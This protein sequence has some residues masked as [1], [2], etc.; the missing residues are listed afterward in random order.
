MSSLRPSSASFFLR[1]GQAAL[2]MEFGTVI[3][4]KIRIASLDFHNIYN[5]A[6]P[7][8]SGGAIPKPIEMT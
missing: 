4:W 1:C 6:P 8:F 2:G 7:I 3:Y 5:F